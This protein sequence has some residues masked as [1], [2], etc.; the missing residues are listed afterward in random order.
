MDLLND[1]MY[2]LMVGGPIAVIVTILLTTLMMACSHEEG[3][4]K[5]EEC[6]CKG[7][8]GEEKGE[9][10]EGEEKGEC[11]DEGKRRRRRKG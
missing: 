2:L 6:K 4:C 11:E 8:E 7:E 1:I 3:E 5:C 9:E 10:G